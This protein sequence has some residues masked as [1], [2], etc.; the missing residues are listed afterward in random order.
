MV[1]SFSLLSA[2]VLF[3][4]A[5][6]LLPAAPNHR[7]RHCC[8]GLANPV[9]TILSSAMMLRES[10]GMAAEADLVEAACSEALQNGFRTKDI[11][12][13]VSKSCSTSDMGDA[14]IAILKA[15]LA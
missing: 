12:G 5:C 9:G 2:R 11:Q 1:L 15:K 10:L 13:S 4:P 7:R 8:T 6:S 3:C 14:I